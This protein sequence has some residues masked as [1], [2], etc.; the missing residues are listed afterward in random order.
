MKEISKEIFRAY[1]IRGMS[2]Q[3]SPDLARRVGRVIVEKTKAKTVVVGRDARSTSPE[4]S[5]AV[6]EGVVGAGAVAVEIG[7]C[8]TP[9]FNFAVAH[10]PEHQAG[11][12]VTASHNPPQFNGFKMVGKQETATPIS[13]EEIADEVMTGPVQPAVSRGSTRTFDVKSDYLERCLSLAQVPSLAGLKVVIDAGN[14]M[15]GVVIP[16]LF[17]RLDCQMTP[18]FMELD[19]TFPNHE[20]NPVKE[21]TLSVLRERLISEKF[22]LGVAFDGDADRVVFLD[23]QARLLRGDHVLALLAA[24]LLPRYPGR[25]IIYSPNTSWV[26]PEVIRRFGGRPVLSRVG[27]A[28]LKRKMTEEDGLIGGEV[29][30]HFFFDNFYNMEASDYA[31]LLVLRILKESGQTL[32]ELVAPYRDRYVTTGEINLR[33]ND[34]AAALARLQGAFVAGAKTISRLDGVRCDFDDWWFNARPSNTEPLL[35]LVIE[36]TTERI[37]EEK[38]EELI[39]LATSS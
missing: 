19:G 27:H 24:H 3:L 38:R 1:D 17:S 36:A 5:A 18:I 2:D 22:D 9:L 32:S 34:T 8:S 10:Y 20:P 11:I 28:F 37:L 23:E 25:A 4:L 21:E 16:D 7:L 31:L 35:R 12:M 6:I 29:S 15:A 14:G 33:V 30:G 39:H 13:G 26:V